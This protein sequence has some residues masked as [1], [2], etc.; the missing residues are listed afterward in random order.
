M[1]QPIELPERVYQALLQAAQSSGQTP[2]GW[3]EERPPKNGVAINRDGVTDAELIAA[4]AALDDCLVSA[5]PLGADNDQI[6]ADLVLEYDGDTEYSH[7][8]T[9]NRRKP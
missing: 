7:E 5:G 9:G 6:D 2:A 8:W 3:I 4:D 1:N